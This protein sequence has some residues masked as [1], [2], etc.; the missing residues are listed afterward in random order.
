M[1]H[2]TLTDTLMTFLGAAVLVA[3]PGV[4]ALA[5]F[6][7]LGIPIAALAAAM[8]GSGFSYVR[9]KA[10]DVEAI[11]LRLFGIAADAFIG[12]W[13]AVVLFHATVLE[14]YGSKA[15]P[16]EAI[17]GLC[18]FLMQ[19]ARQKAGGY[20]ERAFQAVLNAWVGFTT[21]G[22]PSREESP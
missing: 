21:R 12:G 5:R 1:S 20:F 4:D 19:V 15:I 9:R 14:P 18:A 2:A 22:K 10:P 16:I 13:I 3:W 8:L 6:P 7:V 11:P 17:A